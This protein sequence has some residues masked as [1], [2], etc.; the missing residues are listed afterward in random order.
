MKEG[1]LSAQGLDALRSRFQEQSRRAQAYYTV[2]H[3][4]RAIAGNDDAASA[5]MN[6]PLP[7]FDGR[8]PAQLVGDGREEEVLRYIDSLGA[9]ASG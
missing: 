5:W 4:A 9:G 2:M 8:T 1:N 3:S 6:Q 7:S